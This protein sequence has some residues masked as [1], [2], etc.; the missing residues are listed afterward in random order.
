MAFISF[1]FLFRIGPFQWV[2]ADSN[3]KILP[4]FNSR[5]GL[6]AEGFSCLRSASAR[7]SGGDLSIFRPSRQDSI[8]SDFVKEQYIRINAP[9]PPKNAEIAR[10]L[11]CS[12]LRTQTGSRTVSTAID[13]ST[14]RIQPVIGKRGSRLD[15]LK[16]APILFGEPDNIGASLHVLVPSLHPIAHSG[17]LVAQRA[18]DRNV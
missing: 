2:T 8:D 16:P 13:F 18:Q 5:I 10:L 17:Q 9:N 6:C 12:G 3:K 11:G 15:R 1:H 4:R 14:H 7:G